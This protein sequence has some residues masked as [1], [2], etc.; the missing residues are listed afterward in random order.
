MGNYNFQRDLEQSENM[1]KE[2]AQYLKAY[3]QESS[4]YIISEGYNPYFDIFCFI[5]GKSATFEV[6]DDRMASKTGNV[7]IEYES[8]GFPSGIANTKADY[9][10]F[11]IDNKFYLIATEAL[12]MHVLD[13]EYYQ[14]RTGG[15][16]GSFTKM[17]LVK[18]NEFISW[19]IL[20]KDK[21]EN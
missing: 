15:D 19:C 2:V 7:A 14:D 3:F 10:V 13:G 5:K 1:V 20:M 11:R 12:I 6:K 4:G 18:K 16:P 21:K 17:K 9:W 8:R